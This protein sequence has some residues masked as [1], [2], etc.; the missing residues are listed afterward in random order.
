MIKGSCEE[1]NGKV[2]MVIFFK[3]ANIYF[4]IAL[5]LPYMRVKILLTYDLAFRNL[6]NHKIAF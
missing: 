6:S 4:A 1:Y 2:Y 3:I 5:F